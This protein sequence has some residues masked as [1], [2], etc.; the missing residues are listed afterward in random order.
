MIFVEQLGICLFNL[1]LCKMKAKERN[2]ND[3]TREKE[4]M[5]EY[6][7]IILIHPQRCLRLS[8]L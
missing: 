7:R 6:G 4:N 1:F 5:K 8:Q 3:S 2:K